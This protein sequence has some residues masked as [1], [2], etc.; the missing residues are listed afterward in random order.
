MRQIRHIGKLQE[1]FI[2]A[3]LIANLFVSL[4]LYWV[5]TFSNLRRENH[6]TESEFS[7]G[8]VVASIFVTVA[9]LVFL[10]RWIRGK[11]RRRN[12]D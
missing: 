4:G 9:V 1:D 12:T 6:F 7:T 3:G 11:P 5:Q 8:L 2:T 10:G